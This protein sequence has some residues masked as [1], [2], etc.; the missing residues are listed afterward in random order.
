MVTETDTIEINIPNPDTTTVDALRVVW[1]SDNESLLTVRGVIPAATANRAQILAAKRQAIVSGRR[2]G[3]ARIVATVNQDGFETVEISKS[4]SIRPW[5]LK[6]GGVWPDTLTVTQNYT[7]EINI[8]NPDTTTVDA[9]RVLWTSDNES[10]LSVRPVVPASSANRKQTLDAKRTAIVSARAS[11]AARVV[12]TITQEG[13]E[14]VEIAKSVAVRSWGVKPLG[15]WPDSLIVTQSDTIEIDIP[16]PDTVAVDGLRVLWT[17]DDESV[18]T[19]RGVVP[20]ESANRSQILAAKRQ[21]IVTGRRTGA[22]RLIATVTQEGFE[23]VQMAKS[24]AIRPWPV[25]QSGIWPDTLTV[26]QL[27]TI[28]VELPN[29]D[30]TAVDALRVLWVSDDENVL[31]VRAM[32]PSEGANRAQTLA[33]KRMA[34]V[35]ARRSGAARVIAT[36]SR[37][38]FETVEIQKPTVIRPLRLQMASAWVDSLFVEETATADAVAVDH[39]GNPLLG[40][41]VRWEISGNQFEADELAETRA[42]ITARER[43]TADL[44]AAVDEVGFERAALSHRI[45]IM[46]R[47]RAVSAGA[48]HTCGL[49]WSNKIYC[50]GEGGST[51]SDNR[52]RGGALG[53][54]RAVNLAAPTVIAMTADV[55]FRSVSAGNGVSCASAIVAGTYCWGSGRRGSLG[56]NDLSDSDQFAP[57][58]TAGGAVFTVVSAN[59]TS[60][61]VTQEGRTMCWGSDE[62]GQVAADVTQPTDE[63]LE[64]CV[65]IRGP[66]PT[67]DQTVPCMRSPR[68]ITRRSPSGVDF[69]SVDV[70]TTHVCSIEAPAPNRAFCWGQGPLG[71]SALG[72]DFPR[73]IPVRSSEMFATVTAGG[74]HSCAIN[75]AG[76][77]FCWGSGLAGQLGTGVTEN[78]DP[79]AVVGG[80]RFKAIS[81]GEAHTCAVQLDGRAY[82][83]GEGDS[84]RLGTQSVSDQPAPFLVNTNQVFESIDAGSSHTCAITP[85]GA[86]FCWGAGDFGQLGNGIF[87]NSLVPVRVIEPNH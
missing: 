12:A 59:L 9:L 60:C 42:R 13:F 34:I 25:K 71:N 46:E 27:D 28:E 21:A 55:R 50:W 24:L 22:V 16:S 39:R 18:A 43:G 78:I 44:V 66:S 14:P 82:C 15:A 84:G 49:T 10:V 77:A 5:S 6:A 61:G 45:R 7:I 87:G 80:L 11:G 69:T 74:T 68:S 75:G 67:Q 29:T 2:T 65:V 52:P 30:T 76:A 38:G 41:H 47:W 73:P 8:P 3:L 51:F 4:V 81:A 36:V 32:L 19:I 64:V 62:F 31:T 23:S 70:S 37:D 40:R 85:R 17:S 33:A 48:T 57:V 1:A 56:N 26:T 35:T 83:W 63:R 53:N 72:S 79:L 20:G 54:G 58:L 86:L